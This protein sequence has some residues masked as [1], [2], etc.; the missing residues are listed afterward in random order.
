MP[1]HNIFTPSLIRRMVR[2]GRGQ[3]R[4]KQYVPWHQVR[5][6]E[7]SSHGRS[8][9]IESNLTGRFHHLLSDHELFVFCLATMLAEVRDVREQFP[10]STESGIVEPFGVNASGTQ[11]CFPGTLALCDTLKIKHPSI[12][13]EDGGKE[14]W[15]FTTDLL[16]NLSEGHRENLLAI[17][18]KPDGKLTS[19]ARAKLNIEQ[20][21]WHARGAK[22]RLVTPTDYRRDICLPAAGLVS[23]ALSRYRVPHAALQELAA[24]DWLARPVRWEHAVCRAAIEFGQDVEWAQRALSQAFWAGILPI[25]W[26]SMGE[27]IPVLRQ[28]SGEE[29][30]AQNVLTEGALR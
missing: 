5:R 25:D 4:G 3:G 16:I 1:R 30:L 8:H 21:Y 6:N 26:R 20:A 11:K 22:W 13:A 9:L 19:R 24:R 12:E 17:S 7:P 29:F 23:W 15:V 2:E 14:N 27:H 28:I 10:L 18:V